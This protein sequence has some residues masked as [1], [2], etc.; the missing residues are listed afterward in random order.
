LYEG[1]QCGL[2][3]KCGLTLR[4]LNDSFFVSEKQTKQCGHGVSMLRN[5]ELFVAS[6]TAA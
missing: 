4:T 6:Q 5:A 3:R 2:L 1:K